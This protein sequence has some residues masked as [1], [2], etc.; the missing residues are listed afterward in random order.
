MRAP[1]RMLALPILARPILAVAA[2]A[3]L[4]ACH[5]TE[6]TATAITPIQASSPGPAQ[7]PG[8]WVQ[9]VSDRRGARVTKICLDAGAAGAL[10]SFDQ[11]LSGHCSR[12]DMARAAD[13]SWHFSTSCD[14]GPWGKV[15]TEGVMRG[16]FASHYVVEARSQTVGAVQTAADGPA[17]VLADIRRVGDCP[18]DM[19]P[20]DVILP[21]GD[22]ARIDQLSA[23][24]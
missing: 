11:G 6:P 21:G 20:G 23:H 16:D 1:S 22:R 12:R 13:G 18:A 15:A 3:A 19:K 14:M 5:R 8:L 4:G 9:R 10:A 17:R 24:A 2:L 7:T